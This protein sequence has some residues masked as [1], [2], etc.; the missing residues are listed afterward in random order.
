MTK[1]SGSST[2]SFG[3]SA[4]PFRAKSNQQP[5]SIADIARHLECLSELIVGSWD[6]SNGYRA[7]EIMPRHCPAT[8]QTEFISMDFGAWPHLPALEDYLKHCD[9]LRL[10]NPAWR[11]NAYNFSAFVDRELQTAVVW[12][13]SGPSSQPAN[14]EG[15]WNTH[16]E[17][18]SKLKWRRREGDGEWE[19]YCHSVIRGGGVAVP[20]G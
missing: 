11:M 13:T 9:N 1:P 8:F 10:V 18:V 7:R 17:S 4:T 14:D 5:A 2:M 19:C 3:S 20:M 6:E 15:N 16:R 12:F